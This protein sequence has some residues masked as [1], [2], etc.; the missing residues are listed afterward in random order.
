M[1]DFSALKLKLS[2]YGIN[3]TENEMM[4][5]HTSFKIGG[6]ADLFINANTITEVVSAVN[7]LREHKVEFLVIGKGT[8]LLV[9]DKGI[10]GAVVYF[11]GDNEISLFDE[12]FIKVSAGV[13]LNKLC[14][15]ARD[16]SLTGLEFAY[17]IPGGVGGAVFM[18]AGAYDGCMSDVVLSVECLMPDGSIKSFDN[19]ECDFSYRKSLFQNN[20]A[21]IL[22][23]T[24]ELKEGQKE[25][26]A[27]KMTDLLS[28]R[29]S[30]QPLE[31]PSA[32]S[33]FKRP[34]GHYAGALIEKS[35]LKGFS[36]GGAE[37]SQKH[38]GFVINTNDATCQDV[39]ILIKKIQEKVLNDSGVTLDP[40]VK[41]F[42]R[43]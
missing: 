13:S 3:Y 19:N 32:G 29:K 8:N 36:V 37:V 24:L 28:R 1:Q 41:F 2:E 4:K 6:P 23:A 27:D 17:G 20:G 7:I 12:K 15:F 33:T 9:S 40:E 26:I 42:G 21:V 31:Y 25:T 22:S 34:V 30:K 16:N 39:L 35:G 43:E 38:S 5:F 18:N 14:V 11:G 10:E